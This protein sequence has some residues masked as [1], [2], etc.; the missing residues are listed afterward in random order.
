[1]SGN[2]ANVWANLDKVPNIV[3]ILVTAAT[4]LIATTATILVALIAA[5]VSVYNT[6]NTLNQSR[7]SLRVQ[8]ASS[9]RQ[10]ATFIAEKR[11]KWIDDL[12]ADV[13]LYVALTTLM[14][15]G[16]KRMIGEVAHAWDN[17]PPEFP[18]QL[19][20]FTESAMTYAATIAEHESQH[21]R[22]LTQI[23]L[24]LN[25]EEVA[26]LGLVDRL[27]K[28]RSLLADLNMNATARHVYDNQ[29]IFRGIEHELQ[30]AQIYAKVILKE[31]W[32]KL[33][34]E[35]ANPERLITEILATSAPDVE[36]M[37]ALVNKTAPNV[38]SPFSNPNA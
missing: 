1:M 33:K 8:R 27:F 32:Q 18:S 6:R 25:N 29:E 14:V 16:W 17:A 5:L 36:T 7:E 24:R 26:H 30:F 38:P 23:L 20:G 4:A 9:D 12:R 35:V 31:E 22:L 37:E 19:H 21:H 28:V 34:R 15:E 3:Q 13:S 10:A 2:L 11:Q